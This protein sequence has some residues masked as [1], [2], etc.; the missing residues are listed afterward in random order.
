MAVALFAIGPA[1]G[2]TGGDYAI[3]IANDAFA[4]LKDAAV[5]LTLCEIFK[6]RSTNIMDRFWVADARKQN[7]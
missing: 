3:R 7:R 2:E 5:S 6:E 1:Q 4:A